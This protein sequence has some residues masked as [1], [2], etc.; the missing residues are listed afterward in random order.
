M[1]DQWDLNRLQS[2]TLGYGVLCGDYHVIESNELIMKSMNDNNDWLMRSSFS[3]FTQ[4]RWLQFLVD[5]QSE[6]GKW[7]LMIEFE[8]DIPSLSEEGIEMEY[9]DKPFEEVRELHSS[10]MIDWLIMN[11]MLI[12]LIDSFNRRICTFK[13]R[14][15]TSEIC[16]GV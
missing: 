11:E 13:R 8:L 7:W 15:Y 6:I 3:F 1:N 14:E 4:R 16:V 2:I 12:L 9:R 10:S 5:R